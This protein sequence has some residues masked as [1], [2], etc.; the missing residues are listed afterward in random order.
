MRERVLRA[1]DHRDARHG[2]R[3]RTGAQHHGLA[4]LSGVL[5]LALML[6]GVGASSALA[7]GGAPSVETEK[8]SGVGHTSVVLNALVNPN[9]S[10]VSE[11]YFEYGTSESS[12][13]SVAPCSYSPGAGVTPVHV[14]ASVEGLPESTTY[15]F[16]I[17]AKSSQGESLGSM[18]QVTTLPTAPIL[19]T[20]VARSVGHTTATLSGFVTPEDSEVTECFFMWGATANAL[21]NT[22]PCSPEK[23]GAGSEP[24]AVTAALSG[25]PESTTYFFR[26]VARNSFGVVEGGRSSFGTLPNKPKANTEPA[27]SVGHTSA[28]LK[29]FVT[30]NGGLVQECYFRW[31]SGSLTNSAPCEPASLGSGEEPVA[32]SAALAGLSESTSYVFRLVAINSFGGNEAGAYRFTTLPDLPKALIHKPEELMAESALLRASVDPEDSAISECF[33]EFGTTP[34]LGQRTAC[35]TLPAAGEKYVRV[36]AGVSGLAPTTTYVVRLMTRNA[37]GVTYSP[38]ESFTTSQTGLP[39][40][41]KKVKPSKGGSAGGTAV[42]ITG[43]N[44]SGA[45]AVSFGEAETTDITQDSGGSLTVISPPGVA[46]QTVDVVVRTAS[47]ESKTS[48]ADHFTYKGPTITS[49]SPGSAP[50]AGGTQVTVT[51]N[52]FEPGSEGTIFTFGSTV[53][54]AECASTTTCTVTVPASTET[55]SARIRATVNGKKSPSHGFTY[56]A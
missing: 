55:G 56:T 46:V 10:A 37:F 24:V 39:P 18:G 44:L 36:S 48:S 41:V 3:P 31:G 17:D 35:S 2:Q 34:A 15:Y 32:V 19:N 45:I 50:K 21:D 13:G 23:P 51:G 33:F 27:R 29:G 8:P 4:A 49:V 22:A 26:V 25:L 47:G 38:E 7:G 52:G 1:S 9:G 12:L 54:E 20:E 42:T 5:A 28:T 40:V 11:C 16:R 14:L 53:A 43:E 6:A 30:P